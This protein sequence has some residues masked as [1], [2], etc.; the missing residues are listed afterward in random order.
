MSHS[1]T[2]IHLTFCAC[3]GYPEYE[4]M[5]GGGEVSVTASNV[6]KY[7]EDVI[8]ATLK[9][10]IESQLQAFRLFYSCFN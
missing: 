10:G 3:V 6:G 5:E 1:S 7:I 4:L 2:S 9:Q 8:D